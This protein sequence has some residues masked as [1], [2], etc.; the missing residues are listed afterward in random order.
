M[1]ILINM[2]A[3]R[4][5]RE[6]REFLDGFIWGC[7]EGGL[8]MQILQDLVERMCRGLLGYDVR[9]NR[10][11][12]KASVIYFTSAFLAEIIIENAEDL[13]VLVGLP[14]NGGKRLSRP[15]CT[16]LLTRIFKL[17]SLNIL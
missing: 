11:S 8:S 4:L 3:R 10:E 7:L 14:P 12:N 16:C 13:S 2:E 17:I 6:T 5:F 15:G 9:T 1:T